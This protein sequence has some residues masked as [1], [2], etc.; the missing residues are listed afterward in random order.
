MNVSVVSQPTA[1][2][3]YSSALS[4]VAK[5]YR[6][7][8]TGLNEDVINFEF[9]I[10]N[11]FYKPLVDL[12]STPDNSRLS[13]FNE[14]KTQFGVTPEAPGAG[15]SGFSTVQPSLS[16]I[17]DAASDR[18]LIA[19]AQQI[20]EIQRN[21]LP[22]RYETTASGDAKVVTNKQK[23]AELFN[24]MI[25]NS[26]TDNVVL[27]LEIWGDPYYLSDSDSGNYRAPPGSLYINADSAIDFQRSE[28][29]ILVSFNSAVDYKNNLMIIDPD[30]VFS[31]IYKITTFTST[32]SQG[33]FTQQLKL[34]RRPG[35]NKNTIDLVNKILGNVSV[36]ITEQTILE[37][38]SNANQN[39]D[40]LFSIL[41]NELQKFTRLGQLGI[42]LSEKLSP[43]VNALSQA[44]NLISVGNQIRND[45]RSLLGSVQSQPDG[46]QSLFSGITEKLT[47]PTLLSSQ[48]TQGS[49]QDAAKKALPP[50]VRTA[51]DR[52]ENNKP[53]TSSPVTRTSTV[54]PLS[55]LP[56][57]PT[58]KGGPR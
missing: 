45:I 24:I 58:K 28:I 17:Q 23:L 25:L 44:E 39:F 10:N 1:E 43:I 50:S 35:Q 3:D 32:F 12:Q 33:R 47:D 31:G 20:Q 34:L 16:A 42:A 53:P 5:G 40:K 14:P 6:Y 56:G 38:L 30:T 57:D 13:A 52:L 36:E 27:E 2:I 55:V 21:N 4:N 49:V 26:D 18:Q 7:T 48:I 8:Y 37:Q 22:Y 29:D 51:L 19:K 41:P 54:S 46:I 9:T 15:R 11:S